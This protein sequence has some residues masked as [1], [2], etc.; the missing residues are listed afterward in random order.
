MRIGRVVARRLLAAVPLLLAASLVAYLLLYRAADPVARLR[1]IPGVR[2]EDIAR[3]VEQQGLDEPWYQGWW[4]WLTG[5]LRGDWGVSTTDRGRDAIEPIMD[6]L[7][8]TLELMLLALALSAVLAVVIG[9]VSARREGTATDHVLTGLAYVGFATPVFVA[10]VL[11]Q[12]GA[13]WMRDHGWAII[14]FAAGTVVALAA[15]A[16]VRRG[17]AASRAALAGGVAL[18][19]VSLLLWDRLGGDGATVFFTAQR[20]SFDHEGDLF[21][22]D[23]LQHLVLPVLTLAIVNVAVWS[24]FMRGAM[25]EELGSDHVAAARARGLS[26]RR[27]VLGHALRNATTPLI[28]LAALDLGAVLGGAVVTETVFSWPGMGLLLRD[29]AIA[30]DINVAM[31]IVMLG[32]IAVVLAN[33]LADILQAALDPRVDLEGRR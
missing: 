20:Y 1:R 6:A 29:A 26:E 16:G 18:M 8:A 25:I 24:R 30:R 4:E 32:A 23:H 14:P 3:L 19:V 21:S 2:A 5:F 10:G 31:G 27:V 13:V 12:L 28:T 15:L 33:L 7:P 17:G 22:L 9:V 11:L